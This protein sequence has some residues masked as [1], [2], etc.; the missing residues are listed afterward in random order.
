MADLFSATWEVQTTSPSIRRSE[1]RSGSS[2]TSDCGPAWASFGPLLRDSMHSGSLFELI[3]L[4]WESAEGSESIPL[5]EPARELAFSEAYF[6]ALAE[7]DPASLVQILDRHDLR[8]SDLTFAAEAAGRAR[9]DIVIE[10]LLR[11]LA[12]R[13]PLV[14]EGAIYGLA[15]HLRE[16]VRDVL[17]RVANED[18]SP[19]VREAASEALDD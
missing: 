10:P 13:E 5:H 17:R 7:F 6:A 2:S 9:T 12:H 3:H 19:A 16:D 8:P 1:S 18:T 14:R 15:L 11:L 4:V